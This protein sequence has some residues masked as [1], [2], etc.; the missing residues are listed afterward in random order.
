MTLYSCR[1]SDASDAGG[2]VAWCVHSASCDTIWVLQIVG[3]CFARSKE[4]VAVAVHCAGATHTH[5]YNTPLG[6]GAKRSEYVNRRVLGHFNQAHNLIIIC[7]RLLPAATAAG[8][9]KSESH[10]PG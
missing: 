2:Q 3:G 10:V 4:A 6:E 7:K 1:G 9:R 8:A 5:P